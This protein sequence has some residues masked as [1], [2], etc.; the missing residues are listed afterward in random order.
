MEEKTPKEEA[1]GCLEGWSLSIQ[2]LDIQD[3]LYMN[4]Y[5]LAGSILVP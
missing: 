2:F 1:G 3:V 5:F 4:T